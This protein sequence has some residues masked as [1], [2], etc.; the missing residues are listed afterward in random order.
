MSQVTENLF[1][2][3]VYLRGVYLREVDAGG[4]LAVVAQSLADDRGG[5]VLAAGDAGP[6]VT[7]HIH[8]E[9]MGQLEPL[10]EGGQM[11]VDAV[12]R[13]FV[14]ASLPA[15]RLD[16]GQQEGGA[17]RGI[18][19][20]YLLHL[21]LPLDGKLLT[22]LLPLVD[23]IAAAEVGRGEIGHVDERH[24]PG[25]EAE[26][27]HVAGESQLG[28]VSEVET[29]Q[30]AYLAQADGTLDGLV[31]AHI[32]MAE[33]VAVGDEL[34]LDG[35]VVD[36]AEV[37]QIER[38]GVFGDADAP[39]V[40]LVEL[41]EVGVDGVEL[42]VMTVAEAQEAV[43]CGEEAFGRAVA[44]EAPEDGNALLHEVLQ[45]GICGGLLIGADHIVGSKA[46][47]SG[48]QAFGH[49]AKALEVVPDGFLYQL[50]CLCPICWC[51]RDDDGLGRR[52]PL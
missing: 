16:D 31:D 30:A 21:A 3:T 44:P 48:V 46:V 20:D 52:V 23:E 34:L 9:R 15:R 18:A 43:Q 47:G 38:A 28:A 19:V 37:A 12:L 50:E 36:G 2:G 42:H 29:L 25:V 45:G 40:S 5:D 26:H 6:G 51:R 35:V 17:L 14:V 39:Q 13:P 7:R 24:A 10:G 1:I 41:H 4:L 33:G 27:E 32:D 11:V 8:G 49:A 22:G